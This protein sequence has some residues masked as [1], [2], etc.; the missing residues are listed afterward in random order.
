MFP[1]LYSYPTEDNKTPSPQKCQYAI[2]NLV[3][4]LG[5]VMYYL[6]RYDLYPHFLNSLP[7]PVDLHEC[8]VAFGTLYAMSQQAQQDESM[9]LIFYGTNFEHL[10]QLLRLINFAHGHKTFDPSGKQLMLMM[11]QTFRGLGSEVL[12]AAA[13][14]LDPSNKQAIETL[15]GTLDDE[16]RKL[17]EGSTTT[18]S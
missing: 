3:G 18:E 12:T 13:S 6:R 14:T 4:A 16:L 15:F 8:G 17:A 7:L 5:S 9:R 11:A 2:D 10:P 1:S